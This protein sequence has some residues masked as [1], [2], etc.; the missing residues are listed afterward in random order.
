MIE[1]KS[2]FVENMEAIYKELQSIKV[3]EN[4]TIKILFNKFYDVMR[5]WGI[6]QGTW[7]AN[8][9]SVCNAEWCMCQMVFKNN[10]ESQLNLWE[11]MNSV[12]SDLEAYGIKPDSWSES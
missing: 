5:K 11:L 6:C 7:T 12:P 10:I 9:R 8:G 2:K 1:N 3:E 4:D